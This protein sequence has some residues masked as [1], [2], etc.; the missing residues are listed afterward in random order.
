MDWSFSKV[1]EVD[2]LEAEFYVSGLLNLYGYLLFLS[3]LVAG[4][5]AILFKTISKYTG[6]K[7]KGDFG[8][9]GKGVQKDRIF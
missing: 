6:S 3:P 4:I 2:Q 7:F 1:P 5:P 8:G 9:L